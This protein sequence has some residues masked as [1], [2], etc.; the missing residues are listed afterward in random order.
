M[1][2]NYDYGKSQL[3]DTCFNQTVGEVLRE[4]REENNLSLQKVA[5]KIMI[6]KQTIS[7]YETGLSKIRIQTFKKLAKIYNIDPK[8][9]YNIIIVRFI[10][11]SS[12]HIEKLK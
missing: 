5:S 9:L 7:K 10:K 8:D 3:L 4:V 12:S 6:S 11:N 2:Y 1:K